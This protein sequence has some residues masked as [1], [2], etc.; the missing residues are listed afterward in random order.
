MPQIESW[1]RFPQAVRDHLIERM[2]DRK[3]SI[4]DLNQ[5][6]LWIET[7]P[8]VPEGLW[9]K[10]FGSFKLCGEGALPKTFLLADQ[11]AKGRKV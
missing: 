11:V 9:Y 4:N 6:R 10:D 7:K 3:I 8:I 5:L 1:S 2:R